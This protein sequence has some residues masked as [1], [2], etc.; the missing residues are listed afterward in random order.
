V[1]KSNLIILGLVF[2]SNF[3]FAQFEDSKPFIKSY[4]VADYNASNQNWAFTQDN[5]GVLYIGNSDGILEFDGH[6]WRLIVTPNKSAIRI[7]S[8]NDKG[9]IYVGG[10]SEFGYLSPDSIGNLSFVSLNERIPTEQQGYSDIWNIHCSGDSVFFVTSKK[11]F[12]INILKD[13]LFKVVETENILHKSFLVNNKLYV[14]ESKSGLKVFENGNLVLVNHGEMFSNSFIL[15]MIAQKDGSIILTTRKD[16]ILRMA[17]NTENNSIEFLPVETELNDILS[18]NNNFYT[19][20]MSDGKF[21]FATL[22]NGIIITDS[23][24]NLFQIINKDK[25]LSDNVVINLY[26]DIFNNLWVAT[27]DG[28]SVIMSGSPFSQYSEQHGLEGSIYSSLFFDNTLFSVGAS[29]IFYKSKNQNFNKVADVDIQTW[30]VKNIDNNIFVGCRYGLSILKNNKLDDYITDDN[31]WEIKNIENTDYYLVGTYTYGLALIKKTETGFKFINYIKGYEESCRF[32]EIDEFNN[33][34]LTNDNQGIYRIKLNEKLDSISTLEFYGDSCGLPKINDNYVFKVNLHN[35]NQIVFATNKGIYKF[36]YNTN[37]FEPDTFFNNIIG[38]YT[39]DLFV[40][41]NDL[42]IWIQQEIGSDYR[43]AVLEKQSDGSYILNDTLFQKF[44]D[45]YIENIS[46]VEDKFVLFNYSDGLIIYN[47][48]FENLSKTSIK[49]LIRKVFVNGKLHFYGCD[50][51]STDKIEKINYK[52]NSIKFAYS[53]LFF[54]D[55]NKNMYSYKLENFDDVWSEW[56][57]GNEKEYTNLYEGNYIFKVKSKN[58]YGVESEIAEYRFEILTPWYRTYLAYFFYLV[59]TVILILLLIKLFTRKLKKDKEHLEYTVKERTTEILMQNAILEQQNEEIQTQA[60]NLVEINKILSEKNEEINLQKEEI[61]AQTDNLLIANEQISNQKTEIETA[62]KNLE[63]INEIG[64]AVT[65]H[66]SVEKIIETLYENLTKLINI[67]VFA[68]GVYNSADQTLEFSGAKENGSELPFFTDNLDNQDRLSVICYNQ[69]KEILI[70]NYFDEFQIYFPEFPLPK[71]GDITNSII[72]LPLKTANKKLGVLTVQSFKTN[73]YT[74]SNFETLKYLSIYI[75]IA[76][77]NADIFKEIQEKKKIIEEKNINITSSINYASRIQTALLPDNETLSSVFLDHFVIWKPRDI[78][79]GDFYWLRIVNNYK[80]IAVADCTGHGVPGAFVS[81]LGIAFLN[82][83]VYK[84]EITLA[85]QVLNLLRENVKKSLNQK[86]IYSEQKDGMD[87]ALCVINNQT[88]EFQ[89]AGAN[90]SLIIVRKKYLQKISEQLQN[91]SYKE[92]ETDNLILTQILGNAQPI[93]IYLKETSFTNYNF[94][95]LESDAMYL[96]TDGFADQ[97][98]GENKSKFMSKKLKNLLLTINS[99]TMT[100]Q[101]QILENEFDSWKGENSQI[102]DILI[103]G[104]E[105]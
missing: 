82:D 93:G 3:L 28:I 71:V 104:F 18:E 42:N 7:L 17:K 62:F 88:S 83:I 27:G 65:K 57:F 41:D 11:L 44:K 35:K 97:V 74:F 99:K 22:I 32:F 4:F 25:G 45:V 95:Y 70:N 94:K 58:I 103:V 59:L 101:R 37:R 84:K 87:I 39:I 16:G 96:F 10:Q 56:S 49:S 105:I 47:R 5:R 14:R 61:Q 48:K 52:D 85:A 54:E 79:S 86:G 67:E 29:G 19:I 77:E 6:E 51:D 69:Q 90:N 15:G 26:E 20:Q 102:D 78:V 8:K 91:K 68:V 2:I 100:E 89:F 23:N 75:S 63:I 73:A 31:I 9:V 55:C 34:W 33:I 76:L 38:D 12:Y 66:L 92:I 36:N 81:M 64:Q 40:Q 98:G 24:F 30:F 80:I 43:R 13:S 53:S 21:I 72:Y 50:N 46:F 60:D 1:K